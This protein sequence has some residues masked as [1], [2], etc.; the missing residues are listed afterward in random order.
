MPRSCFQNGG[1]EF[2]ADMSVAMPSLLEWKKTHGCFQLANR[3]LRQRGQDPAPLLKRPALPEL[4]PILLSEL[5][6]ALNTE[7]RRLPPVFP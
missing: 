4:P 2:H 6:E 5:N 3:L 1:D 7:F